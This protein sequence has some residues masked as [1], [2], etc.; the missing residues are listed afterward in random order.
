MAEVNKPLYEPNGA[1]P[2]LMSF[3]DILSHVGDLNRWQLMIF[4]LFSLVVIATSFQNMV[5][6]FVGAIPEHWCAVPELAA[7][8]YDVQKNLSIPYEISDEGVLKWSACEV[9]SE[10]NYTETALLYAS[11]G[12]DSPLPFLFT[13]GNQTSCENGWVYDQREGASTFASEWDV[14]CD[15]SWLASATGQ[16]LY[17]LGFLIGCIVFGEIS[18]RKGRKK[19]FLLTVVILG[20]ACTASA[21]APVY[22]LYIVLRVI[23]GASVA[24][25][26]NSAYCYLIENVGSTY[27]NRCSNA[28]SMYYG[29]GCMLLALFAWLVP[30]WRH[31][32]FGIS[33][34]MFI[35]LGYYFL[36][37][38]SPRWLY[39][40]G[41]HKECEMV[42]RK[43]A[44]FNRKSYPENVQMILDEKKHQIVTDDGKVREPNV[45]DTLRT[46]NMRKK[47][48]IM[49]YQWFVVSMV[50]YGLSLNSVNLGSNPYVGFT[51]ASL[52]EIPA[53]LVAMYT[54]KR[55]GRRLT[56]SATML[57]SGISCLVTALP[58]L[59][60]FSWLIVGLATF[61]KFSVSITFTV[62]Y[63]YSAEIYPTVV[64]NAGVG[65]NSVFARVG[66]ILAPYISMLGTHY[67]TV[68][69]PLVI[70]GLPAVIAGVLAMF[71]PETKDRVLP[72]T[73]NNGEQFGRDQRFWQFMPRKV[74][75]PTISEPMA[76]PDPV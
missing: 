70:F 20:T 43:I 69:L 30:V 4:L 62:V 18:D 44:A 49:M 60:G 22:P 45:M 3:D 12:L 13:D 8:P 23:T 42:L 74:V 40:E 68:T 55:F 67:S 61:G 6:V 48:L 27:R 57:A 17:M 76:T 75:D 37:D 56:T 19:T 7:L 39:A 28:Y 15:K 51:L 11:G 41:K 58:F 33:I 50:Y 21:F 24:G 34:W 10:R 14:V 63:L 16:S 36:L 46:P 9:Y 72:E 32:Q 38:E 66:A 65:S 73:L 31:L 26:Y 35:L 52:V 54:M 5:I 59:H 2:R 71:L 64:R 1:A 47:S 29:V 25:F 53:H